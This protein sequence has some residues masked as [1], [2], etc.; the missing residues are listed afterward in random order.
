[1]AHRRR[2]ARVVGRGLLAAFLLPVAIWLVQPWPLPLRWVD[3]GT[4]AFM[5]A[6]LRDARAA[7]EPLELRHEW[8]PLEELPPIL[9][10]AVLVAED[11]RFREHR[12][13]DWEALAE[14]VRY[15]GPI[16]P[17]LRDEADRAAL[18]AAWRY[19]REHRN[20]LRGRSTL[21]QQ[22]ARNLYLSTDRSFVRKG[23]EFLLARRLE[24]FLPKDRILEIYLNVAEFGPGVFGVEA[25]AQAYFDRSAR[26]L[27]RTQAASL[28]ATLPHPL[29][30]N[31]GHRPARM[32]W[33]R[34]L[35]L[36]RLAGGTAPV[37]APEP[38]EVPV[39][40]EPTAPD[41]LPLPDPDPPDTIPPD[42]IP[43]DTLRPDT[44]RPDTIRPDTTRPGGARHDM[45]SRDVVGANAVSPRRDR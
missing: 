11:D 8:V 2:G 44:I 29:S 23:Q 36:T 7:G 38:P 18:L 13:V 39:I 22:L 20:E 28:A 35:I 4:T 16:P 15:R 14:E 6:R 9:V 24:F 27:T 37:P 19:L 42:S 45:D 30:S 1:V 26:E 33:R 32:A 41:P 3:P 12:G 31:P 5:D 34:D 43:P 17:N 40:P 21:T 25:A 10:Q